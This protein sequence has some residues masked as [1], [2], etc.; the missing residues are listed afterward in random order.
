[1]GLRNRPAYRVVAIDSHRA[2]DSRCLEFLGHYDPRRKIL[3]LKMERVRYW[4]TN[5]AQPSAAVSKLI[6]RIGRQTEAPTEPATAPEQQTA[7]DM[8]TTTTEGVQP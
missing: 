1:M 6:R 7:S 4:L 8:A 3:N 5:G 2:R